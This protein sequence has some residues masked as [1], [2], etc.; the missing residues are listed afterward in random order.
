MFSA[1]IL[2]S[3]SATSDPCID[4]Y[5]GKNFF[6]ASKA[7]LGLKKPQFVKI[8]NKQP[9]FDNERGKIFSP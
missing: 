3:T 5:H 9:P 6:P 1:F 4:M 2:V 7:L 8:F